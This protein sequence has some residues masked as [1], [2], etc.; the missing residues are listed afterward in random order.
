M[1]RGDAKVMGR[2][3]TKYGKSKNSYIL[4]IDKGPTFIYFNLVRSTKFHTSQATY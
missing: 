1:E 3:Y 4:K 2:Y